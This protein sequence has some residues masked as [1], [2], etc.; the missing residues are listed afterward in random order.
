MEL[1]SDKPYERLIRLAESYFDRYGDCFLGVGWTKR[2]EEAAARYRVMLDLL[3]P[4]ADQPVTLLDFGCG[5]SHLYEY[6]LKHG[7]RN[8]SYSGL[9]LSPRFLACSREKFPQN[10]YYDLDVLEDDRLPTFDYVVMNGIFNSKTDLSFED[11]LAYCRRLI[12]RVF[13]KT[14]KGLAFNVMSKQVDWE[15]DDLFHL[16]LDRLLTFLSREVSRHVV[17]RHDYGL[18]EYTAYVYKNPTV[19]GQSGAKRLLDGILP[20]DEAVPNVPCPGPDG[21]RA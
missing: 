13:E 12:L 16:P 19:P 17:I 9:D 3:A 6:M 2:Q 8:V 11:M 18:Y 21:E 4:E 15:R 1:V 14:R 20:P 5:A 7:V 10:T